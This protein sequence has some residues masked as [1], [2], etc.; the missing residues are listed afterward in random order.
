MSEPIRNIGAKLTGTAGA[1]AKL[2][3]AG[4]SG[5]SD[6]KRSGVSIC[7]CGASPI[8]VKAVAKDAAAPTVSSTNAEW[9]IAAGGTLNLEV[10][11]SIDLYINGTS[12]YAATEWAK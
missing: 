1:T 4:V 11:R 3:F 5:Y 6:F 2:N 8:Y 9:V 7:S 10:A 12:E